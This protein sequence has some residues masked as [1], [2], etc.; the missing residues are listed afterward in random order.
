MW[1]KKRKWNRTSNYLMSLNEKNPDTKT[2]GYIGKLRANFMGTQFQIYDSGLNPD[3]KGA[4]E[5]TIRKELGWIFYVSY[6]IGIKFT[7][8]QGS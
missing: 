5:Q 7:R 8:D 6:Y 2:P 4:N 3:S 1:G